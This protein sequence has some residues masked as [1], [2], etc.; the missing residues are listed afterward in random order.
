MEEISKDKLSL[1]EFEKKPDG[2][3]VCVRNAD[4]QTK[5]GKVIRVLPGTVFKKGFP[6]WG[7]C[8]VAETL[9]E[10]SSS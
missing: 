4:I 6:L 5:S 8:Q 1:K 3:W 9:D 10:V 7:G 2:T